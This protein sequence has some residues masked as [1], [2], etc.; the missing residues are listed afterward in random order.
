MICRYDYIWPNHPF[1]FI[2]PFQ[3]LN[4]LRKSKKHF[5]VKTPSGICD[6]VLELI[7]DMADEEWIYWAMDDRYLA[8][9]DPSYMEKII[10]FI[11]STES[12]GVDGVCPI[13]IRDLLK[14][15]IDL[16]NPVYTSFGKAF[17][18][19]DWEQIWL[20]QFLKVKVLRFFFTELST[21]LDGPAK[22]MDRLKRD[23]RMDYNLL[24]TEKTHVAFW[25]TLSRGK[26]HKNT[27]FHCFIHGIKPSS[28][29][30]FTENQI[31]MGPIYTS[32]LRMKFDR[33]LW[34]HL[35]KFV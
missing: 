27:K 12:H 7:K 31:R 10:G 29:V 4:V 5:Y 9:V 28:E 19:T 26:A 2:V 25:E 30:Q 1:E 16:D 14:N 6:T 15:S 13:R 3:K 35:Q 33:F 22:D 18:R 8:D 32:S 24:V 23:I 11:D 34:R 21:V 17:N 20:H